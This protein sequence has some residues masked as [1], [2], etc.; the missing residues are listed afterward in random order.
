MAKVINNYLSDSACRFNDKTAI[1]EKNAAISYRELEMIANKMAHFM[2]RA[3]IGLGD[4][5]AIYLDNSIDFI[6][7]IFAIF[8]LAAIY[9]PVNVKAPPDNINKILGDCIPKLIITDTKYLNNLSKADIDLQPYL[10][11]LTNR[12]P[13]PDYTE[14][15]GHLFYWKNFIGLDGTYINYNTDPKNIAYIIYTSG[16]TGTPKGVAIRHES[17]MNFIEASAETYGFD[18][19]TRV[20]NMTPFNF[21]GALGSIFRTILVGGYL[22]IL[23]EKLLVPNHILKIMIDRKISHIGCTPGLFK[24]LVDFI[25]DSNKDLLSLKTLGVGG[26]VFPVNY[27]KKFVKLLP[28]V[29]LFNGYGPTETTVVVA[30][31]EITK[32]DWD[33]SRKIPIG[34]PYRNVNFYTFNDDQC[35]IMPGEVGELYI[36]GI[37]VMEK[38]WNDAELTRA[39][40]K[41]DIVAGDILF[42]TG[43]LVILD[44][45]NNCFF[46]GRIDDMVKKKDYRIYLSEVE[47]ALNK[48]PNIKENCCVSVTNE[49]GE[50]EIIAA[51]VL[52]HPETRITIIKE[53]QKILP[54]YMIP[55]RI[56]FMDSLPQ[57]VIGKA[58][59]I[60]LKE[61]LA[62]AVAN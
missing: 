12:E 15:N 20:L 27:M 19:D 18:E 14:E 28:H 5:V 34:K 17:I 37:Q 32:K 25:D 44:N 3:G 30:G 46:M 13:V 50:A 38:Y 11:L 57:T 23:N 4:R 61:L 53:L 8:K 31:Y 7:S 60:K 62:V 54:L 48:L 51:I 1:E 29:R 56:E 24:H 59:K 45:E 49:N 35:P 52:E 33:G 41:N 58:D 21:D 16:S 6:I 26:D 39:V 22:F 2:E 40:L 47:N 43:D 9:V 10:F 36:G 55:D 42:K